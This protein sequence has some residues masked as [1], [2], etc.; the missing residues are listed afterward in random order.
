MRGHAAWILAV[1]MKKTTPRLA[2]AKQTLRTL[3]TT[4][5]AASQ[6]GLSDP[7]EPSGGSA[8]PPGGGGDPGLPVSHDHCGPASPPSHG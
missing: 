8:S 6:G 2:L 4:Q 1:A 3:T 5:L 7:G